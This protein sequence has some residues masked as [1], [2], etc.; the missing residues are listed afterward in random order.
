MTESDFAIG[1]VPTPN[2]GMIN[3]KPPHLILLETLDEK[4]KL[5]TKLFLS[6]DKPIT[7][8]S[9]ISTKG[10]FVDKTS[11]PVINYVSLISSYPKDGIKEFL[12][13]ICRVFE[14]QNLIFKANK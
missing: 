3:K 9:F 5:T 12:F 10:F 4:N 2:V 13:P 7:E 6:L 14:I 1:V 8:G 11:N